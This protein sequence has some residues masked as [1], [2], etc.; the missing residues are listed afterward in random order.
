M[1]GTGVAVV[2]VVA[3]ALTAIAVPLLTAVA[4]HRRERQR[5]RHER[6]IRD[7]DELRALLDEAAESIDPY[8]DA[9]ASMESAHSTA[10]QDDDPLELMPKLAPFQEARRHVRT[11]NGRLVIRLGRE[12]PVVAAYQ[13]A[14][15][16]VGKAGS[17]V[18]TMIALEQPVS[19][20]LKTLR[21]ERRMNWYA[22]Y[23]G[24]LDAA[25][26]L[27]GSPVEPLR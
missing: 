1:S 24:F 20:E 27:V 3:T 25:V 6:L 9:V 4:A 2:S 15:E 10:Q 7:F 19:P 13:Q 16:V 26:G 22:A 12:H 5:F 17:E 11:L 21:V 8:I 23:E 14:I 18:A